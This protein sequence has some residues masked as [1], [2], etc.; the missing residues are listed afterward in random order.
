MICNYKY[1][2]IIVLFMINVSV[3][4]AVEEPSNHDYS[5]LSDEQFETVISIK[6]SFSSIEQFVEQQSLTLEQAEAA[7]LFV[8][9]RQQKHMAQSIPLKQ[10]RN[11]VQSCEQDVRC[12]EKTVMDKFRGV[13]SFINIVWFLASV[14]I[15]VGVIAVLSIY[16]RFI[17]KVLKPILNLVLTLLSFVVP[18]VVRFFKSIPLLAYELLVLSLAAGLVY[19]AQ[20]FSEAAQVY[21]VFIGNTFVVL[22]LSFLTKKYTALYRKNNKVDVITL[23]YWTKTVLMILFS[24]LWASTAIVYQSQL[25]GFFTIAI[26]LSWLGFGMAISSLEYSFGFKNRKTIFTGTVGALILL[27]I[28]IGITIFQ[29]QVP[30]YSYFENGIKYLG[31]FVFYIGLLI[32]SSKLVSKYYKYNYRLLQLASIVAG[33]AALYLGSIYNMAELRG[34]GGTFFVLYLIEKQLEFTWQKKRIAWLLLLLGITLFAIAQIVSSYPEFFFMT[35][36]SVG[37]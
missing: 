20:F 17:Y 16:R 4:S 5:V 37:E 2:L 14:L 35:T 6:K 33:I 32:S 13:F 24:V 18:I 1:F 27:L 34:F 21:V 7:K 22:I 29:I 12:R 23:R 9:L 8:L 26:I 30:Y 3:V 15:I 36:D 11:L 10:L 25:I 19:S 28:Y 31:S